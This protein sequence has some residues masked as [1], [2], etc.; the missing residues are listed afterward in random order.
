MHAKIL[1]VAVEVVAEVVVMGRATV[2]K[3]AIA[4]RPIAVHVQILEE[5][6][7]EAEEPEEVVV[8]ERVTV[9]KHVTAVRVIAVHAHRLLPRPLPHLRVVMAHAIAEKP[10]QVARVTVAHAP[11]VV[12]M[13]KLEQVRDVRLMPNAE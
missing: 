2:E 5:V 6:V 7:A 12:E 11:I 9:E 4:V 8:M 1:E 10:A 13:E 3:H